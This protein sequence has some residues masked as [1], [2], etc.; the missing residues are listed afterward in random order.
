MRLHM[1][2]AAGSGVTLSDKPITEDGC[3][4]TWD[5]SET[6][7]LPASGTVRDKTA[8]MRTLL[9]TT[10]RVENAATLQAN[11]VIGKMGCGKGTRMQEPLQC[12]CRHPIR[13]DISLVL[14]DYDLNI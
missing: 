8:K 4:M 3:D 12:Y 2:A 14:R 5:L 13:Y 7:C 11:N 6:K 10:V 9:L 1:Q